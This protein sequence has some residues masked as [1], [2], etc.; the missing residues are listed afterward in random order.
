MGASAE[1]KSLRAALYACVGA[2]DQPDDFIGAGRRASCAAPHSSLLALPHL[3]VAAWP[4]LPSLALPAR[5][6]HPALPHRN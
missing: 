2:D 3:S 6:F 4:S 5:Q 1:A